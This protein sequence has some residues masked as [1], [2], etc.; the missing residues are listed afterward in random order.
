MAKC[1]VFYFCPG[2]GVRIFDLSA[3]PQASPRAPRPDCDYRRDDSTVVGMGDHM[4]D[5]LTVSVRSDRS[6][7]DRVGRVVSALDSGQYGVFGGSA[8]ETALD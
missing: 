8:N 7:A 5:F 2:F 3:P 6:A 1:P 4:P